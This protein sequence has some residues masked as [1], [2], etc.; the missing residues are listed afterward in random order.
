MLADGQLGER[1]G[2]WV[3][4]LAEEARRCQR[5]VRD[6]LD[7]AR[8]KDEGRRP[9]ALETIAG[10]ALSLMAHPLRKS[11]VEVAFDVE[12]GLPL[13]AADADEM[14]RVLLNLLT[15]ALHALE[16]QE[17]TRRI[18]VRLARTRS[19]D[20]ELAV[21]DNGPGIPPELQ[22]RVF[23]PFF[24]TKP[25]GK[26]SGL[27]L[28]LVASTVR[29]HG[30]EVEIESTP[31]AG[32]RMVVR[33]P[34]APP[35]ERM[36]A[37]PAPREEPG[38]RAARRAG[39]LAGLRVLVA[40]DDDA[41]AELVGEILTAEGADVHRVPDGIE[42]LA[43][44]EQA[45][46]SEPF[47]AMLCDLGLPRLGGAELLARLGETAPAFVDRVVLATGD[48]RHAGGRAVFERHGRPCLAK[49]FD[50]EALV[51]TLGRVAG[52]GRRSIERGAHRRP[53]TAG[54]DPH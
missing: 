33:L 44:L 46:S 52:L 21:E 43:A 54:P 30:G 20:V 37:E 7:V 34:A 10:K 40:E 12:P 25:E 15:N 11:G 51:A 50:R 42:A 27:G 39:R 35:E 28:A 53:R 24:T 26:G 3:R 19:G 45:P 16:G 8:P 41:V 47:G 32:A 17:G 6:M 36:A 23:L 9:L 5:I 29:E 38:V 13:V 2:H 49:P 48:L 14:L 4:T 31:G 22:D 1:P 18:T